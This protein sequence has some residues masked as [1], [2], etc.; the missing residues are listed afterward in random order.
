MWSTE[1]NGDVPPRWR[2]G[3]PKGILQQVRG[4]ALIPA[5]KS[6]IATDKRLNAVLTFYF[7]EIF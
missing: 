5:Q 1:D 6:L 7:P 2:I 4:V 3:G